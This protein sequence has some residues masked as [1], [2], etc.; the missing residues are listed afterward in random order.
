MYVVP[1]W[2]LKFTAG[3]CCLLATLLV[4]TSTF[5][6]YADISGI[7]NN[8]ASIPVNFSV[9][10]IPSDTPSAYG[11]VFPQIAY[12][13][14]FPIGIK[15]THASMTFGL[16]WFGYELVFAVL[17]GTAMIFT[18]TYHATSSVNLASSASSIHYSLLSGGWML[19]FGYVVGA[20][21]ALPILRKSLQEDEGETI[22]LIPHNYTSFA[23]AS[24]QLHHHHPPPPHPHPPSEVF[25]PAKSYSPRGDPTND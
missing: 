3:V 13:I 15:Q 19:I 1:D 2:F 7:S 9:Q 12:S 11:W 25:P 23:S 4:F 16:F 21:S 8:N 24:S 20:I 6:P 14:V 10:I 17:S 22:S 18:S 5:V